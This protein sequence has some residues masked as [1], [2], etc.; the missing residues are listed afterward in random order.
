LKAIF[1]FLLLGLSVSVNADEG[2]KISYVYKVKNRN[3]TLHVMVW[4]KV[5]S[6]TVSRVII[7]VDRHLSHYAPTC[8]ATHLPVDLSVGVINVSD[9]IRVVKFATSLEGQVPLR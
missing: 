5:T 2:T 3:C 6:E 4:P 8:N 7:A 1:F 9:A